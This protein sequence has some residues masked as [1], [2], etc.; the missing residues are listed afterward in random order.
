MDYMRTGRRGQE[1]P[2]S[3]EQGDRDI[4]LSTSRSTSRS[5]EY[6]DGNDETRNVET[7]ERKEKRK[8]E[9]RA[10]VLLPV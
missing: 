10:N 2:K 8:L 6:R 9:E 5:A 3:D 4:H 7:T 1:K